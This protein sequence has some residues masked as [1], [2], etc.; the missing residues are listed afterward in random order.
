MPPSPKETH[1]EVVFLESARQTSLAL[2]LILTYI[3]PKCPD[4]FPPLKRLIVCFFLV[5]SVNGLV[6]ILEGSKQSWGG[7]SGGDSGG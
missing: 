6:L 4:C 1:Y 5:V 7:D 2:W 3:C